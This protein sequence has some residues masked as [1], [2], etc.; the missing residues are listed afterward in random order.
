[1]LEWTP[2]LATGIEEIDAEHREILRRAGAVEAS[3]LEGRPLPDSVETLEFLATYSKSHFEHEQRLMGET[4]YPDS[5]GHAARHLEIGRQIRSMQLGLS[6]G[7]PAMA[8]AVRISYFLRT[9]IV[10]HIRTDDR[11]LADWYR[12]H[13]SP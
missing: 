6:G 3:L 9:Y 12:E 4:G 2:A 11:G 13:R 1:M 10:E 5:A 7:E 8:L